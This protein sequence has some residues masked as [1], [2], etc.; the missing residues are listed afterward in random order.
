MGLPL[1]KGLSASGRGPYYPADQANGVVQGSFTAIGPSRP[2]VI[3]GPMNLSI[4]GSLNT[5]LTTTA[6]SLAF[7]VAL[8]TGIAPG[9]AVNSVNV[10]K[11]TTVGTIGGT[12]G[13]L[14]LPTYTLWGK[15]NIQSDLVTDLELTDGLL[16]STVTGDGIPA[17]T[18]VAEIIQPWVA[19][20]SG[21]NQYPGQLGIVRLS[22]DVSSADSQDKKIP[23]RFTLSAQSITVSG[24]DSAAIFTG[25][26]IVYAGS[27]QLERS[28]DGGATWIVCNI[29]VGT[30]A[31]FNGGAPISIT[32]GEPEKGVAY[33]LNQTVL[34][35]GPVNFRLSATGQSSTSVS[36]PAI[37]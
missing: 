25:A 27:V 15:T 14:L 37:S 23:L 5:A 11:G 29:G 28:F 16:G 33:R 8:A 20:G 12:S 26:G 32:F 10:P 30:L 21:A 36:V 31:I 19:P 3:Q 35:T 9:T 34:T 17:A 6:A 13:T 24:A 4:W 2:F 7:S 22:Q 18:T 1:T